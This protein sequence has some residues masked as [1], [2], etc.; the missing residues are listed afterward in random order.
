MPITTSPYPKFKSSE[1]SNLA[2]VLGEWNQLGTTW[3]KKC[4]IRI[5]KP[6]LFRIYFELRTNNITSY[7]YG[8]IYRNGSSYGTLHSN[9]SDIYV[10]YIEDLNFQVND[11]CEL[12]TCSQTPGNY[13]YVKDLKIQGIPDFFD[14]NV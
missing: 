14:E 6:S 11:T 10:S 7:A 13:S 4:A 2:S 3:T 8:R 9:L 1:T 5:K 12:W